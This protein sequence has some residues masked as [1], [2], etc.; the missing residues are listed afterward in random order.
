MP[1]KM[2]FKNIPPKKVRKIVQKGF[3]NEVPKSDRFDACWGLGPKVA[4]VGSKD[5]PRHPFKA[6]RSFPDEPKG[7]NIEARVAYRLPA[8]G[9]ALCFSLSVSISLS[10]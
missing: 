1:S 5:P 3:Q 8:N 7:V 9:H 4:G 10:L 2:L 6:P